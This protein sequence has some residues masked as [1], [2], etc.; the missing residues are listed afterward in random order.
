MSLFDLA[1]PL[2]LKLDAETAHGLALATLSRLPAQSPPK[3]DPRLAVSAFGLDF[4]NPVGLAAGFDKH[5]EVP[6]AMLGF[7]FGYVEVGGVTPR[8]Q[9]GNPRPRVFR[10]SAD[11]SVINRMGLNSP[12]VEPVRE[13]LMARRRRPGIVGVNIGPNKDAA[14]RKADYVTLV[15]QLAPAVSYF[16]INVSSPNTAGLR[17]LQAEA[18]LDDLLARIVEARDGVAATAGR[19]P[20]LLKI[21]PDL[22]LE[23]LDG[24]VKVA[25]A[26]GLDGLV[27]S[28]TTISRP[29]SLRDPAAKET[30]GL[31][32]KAVFDLSTRM[33][34][35]TYLRVEGRMP[36]IGVGG[37][38][39]GAAAWTK[40]RAGASLI[41]LYSAMVYH[42]F[43]LIPAIKRDLVR[44]LQREKL[45]TLAQAVGRDAAELTQGGT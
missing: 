33:L 39:S 23:A 36:L 12:G 42:G 25:L 9:P 22:T 32:G 14:D 10:L 43:G 16:T 26:R 34:A 7:G 6:D 8:P 21:A 2:F 28:N 40:I 19:K 30:G 1:R 15:E 11:A 4:P 18:D 3:D 27:V 13:R 17:D 38:D 41:Q 35:Q 31:S 20:L 5:A 37:I 24:V 44:Q 29:A 45:A